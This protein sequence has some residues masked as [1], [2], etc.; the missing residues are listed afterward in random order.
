MIEYGCFY[1]IQIVNTCSLF[2]N[3][4]L[5]TTVV[6]IPIVIPLN[7]CKKRIFMSSVMCMGRK[8]KSTHFQFSRRSINYSDVLEGQK[9]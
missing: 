1:A 9:F 8:S 4:A 3:A 2:R 5:P 7:K 6:C